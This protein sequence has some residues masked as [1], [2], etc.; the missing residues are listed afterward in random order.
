MKDPIGY[1][2]FLMLLTGT[3]LGCF[4]ARL[5]DFHS[6]VTL[7]SQFDHTAFAAVWRPIAKFLLVIFLLAFTAWGTMLIPAVFGIEGFCFGLAV[8]S[9]IFGTGIGSSGTVMITLLFRIIILFPYA[10]LLGG[11]AI[12]RS[13]DFGAEPDSTAMFSLLVITAIVSVAV[14]FFECTF[15]SWL[16]SIY[17]MKIGV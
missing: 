1:T 8:S 16:A 13:A 5:L 14:A 3:I 15:G 2:L 11:W 17:L 6:F 7:S 4:A 12:K 10:F 9:A